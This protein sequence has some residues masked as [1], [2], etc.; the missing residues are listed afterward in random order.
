MAFSCATAAATTRS[1][2]ADDEDEATGMPLNPAGA[3]AW[4][5]GDARAMAVEEED[6]EEA[7]ALLDGSPGTYSTTSTVGCAAKRALLATR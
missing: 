3:T 5:T 1:G 2:E 7:M 6:D 4:V